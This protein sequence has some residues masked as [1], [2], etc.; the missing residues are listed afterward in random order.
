MR[1]RFLGTGASGGTPGRGRSRRLESSLLVRAGTW[2]LLDVTRDFDRQA[3]ALER[4]DCVVLTHA[5]ADACGGIPRLRRWRRERADGPLRVYASEETIAAL[6][7]RYRRLDGL[8]LV[9]VG[10]GEQRSHDGVSLV[11]LAV[12]HA[13]EPH[14]PTYAWRL[15]RGATTLVYASDV[16]RLTG[17]LERFS[18]GAS[19]LVVDGAMWRR[20][21]F[22]HL[23]I[24]RELPRL[25][26][27]EAARILLTQ[28]G[29]TA[30]VHAEL[31]REV[32]SICARAAP[33]HDGLELRLV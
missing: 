18:S 28:I 17:D 21:L 13:R 15:T 8:E 6:R 27:W 11:P 29:R 14:Y 33:A 25:C 3:A 1:L 16:A 23:T 5:H 22:S 24:D 9:A 19:L 26:R 10:S 30:P 20:T 12:P 2:A 4:V 7:R 31:L 32:R